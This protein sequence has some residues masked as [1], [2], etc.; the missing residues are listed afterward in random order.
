MVTV[1]AMRCESGTVESLN[2]PTLAAELKYDGTRV[3]Y[4]KENGKPFVKNRENV[5]YTSRLVDVVEAIDTI[6]SDDIIFDAEAVVY[7]EKGRSLFEYSQRRCS[8]EDPLKQKLLRIKYPMVVETFDIIRLDGKDLTSVP[9]D[10]RKELVEQML[11]YCRQQP[12]EPATLHVAPHTIDD[13]IAMYEDAVK[14]G[15]EGVVVKELHSP[16]VMSRSTH[17]LKVKKWY[18]ERVKIVGYTEGEGNRDQRFGS[19]ILARRDDGGQ[20]VYCGKVG[21]GF[22]WQEVREITKLL[23]A[24]TS[25]EKRVVAVDANRKP[26]PYT[27]VDVSFEVTVR[28]YES[29]KNGVF[30]MPTVMKDERGENM[31]HWGSNTIVGRTSDLRSLLM[32]ITG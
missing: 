1:A 3:W 6:A 4:G 2:D 8:T 26:I 19:L 25:K 31:I 28:F 10:E 27:P 18:N 14:R 9:W 29:S 5:D 17:W 15:E 24:G 12:Y 22:S 21:S 20:L 13:K 7:D 11:K 30:R 23:L 16:Y 32:G